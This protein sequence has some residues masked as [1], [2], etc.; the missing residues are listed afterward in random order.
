MKIAQCRGHTGKL[1]SVAFRAD[2]TRVV[3]A[4]ADGTVRQW[5]AVT[6]REV[7]PPFDHHKGEVLTADY[8]PDGEWVAS[9]G[10][11]HTV[12][13]WRAT[14]RQQCAVLHG[15]AGAVNDLAFS[16][17]GADSGFRE[18]GPAVPFQGGQYCWRLGS[19]F[20]R[21]AGAQRP[22]QVCL[23]SSVQ[24]G[25]TLDCL[26]ELGQH[27]PVVGRYD[28]RRVCDTAAPR[29]VRALAFSPD[30]AWL[31]TG[32]DFP[33]GELLVWDAATGRII[34]QILV[35]DPS[36]QYLVLSPDCSR[37]A[38]GQSGKV[39]HFRVLDVASNNEVGGADG[40]A[41]AYSPDGKWLAGRD[42]DGRSVVLWDSRDLRL[43]AT[44]PGHAG[45]INSISFRRDAARLLSSSSD[46]TVRV[47][48]IATGKCLR[49]FDGH[50]DKVYAAVFHPRRHSR[51]FGGARPGC[52]DLG[53][54]G[55][56]GRRASSGARE[57]Y[58][59]AG[60]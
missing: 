24:P 42:R 13:L 1:L 21:P 43:V 3:T 49:V 46:H 58:L 7:E 22:H 39:E 23:P 28:R 57:L 38:V 53:S 8:S 20:G 9:G 32:G 27:G 25:R 44:W 35:P 34:R 52:L 54:R 55:R 4:S 56:P 48:D 50:T 33:R 37:V 41:L 29:R 47:W 2:G 36:V 15:H 31:I 14:G 45:E 30:G 17:D 40:L 10:A 5:D 51:C 19:E 59:V 26:G 12:R 11:D 18:S 60:V 16:A 6:G